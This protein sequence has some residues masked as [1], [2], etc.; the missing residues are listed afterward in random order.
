MRTIL[1]VRRGSKAPGAG[2]PG[3]DAVVVEPGSL[4][5]MELL[6]KEVEGR[7]VLKAGITPPRVQPTPSLP[8]LERGVRKAYGADAATRS[9]H[10]RASSS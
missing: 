2:A 4:S 8:S 3:V 5:S 1:L 9:G 10:W 6:L 7:V